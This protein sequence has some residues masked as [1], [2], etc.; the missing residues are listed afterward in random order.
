MVYL[1]E[2]NRVFTHHSMRKLF[3]TIFSVTTLLSASSVMAASDVTSPEAFLINDQKVEQ[4]IAQSEDISLR[5]AQTDL[6][7]SSMTAGVPN[8]T[9]R[10]K[11]SDEKFVP[12]LL[13]DLFLGGLGL[14]R[15]YLGTKTMTW[16]GYI[17]SCGGIFGV[18]PLVDLIVMIV[19]N[20]NLSEY[21]GNPKFFMWSK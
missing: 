19:H 21:V 12:A 7:Q 1:G 4:L 18:V 20:D 5:L 13:L 10:V 14:H 16:V 17:L 6:V 8:E 9:T 3:I 11:S 2:E 15:L